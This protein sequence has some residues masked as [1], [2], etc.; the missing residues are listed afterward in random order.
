MLLF[1]L[2]VSLQAQI[3]MVTISSE[4][5]LD[6]VPIPSQVHTDDIDEQTGA[7]VNN[8]VR[9]IGIQKNAIRKAQVK[10]GLVIKFT[11]LNFLL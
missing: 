3:R 1:S 9:Q 4:C 5:A 6:E 11:Y 8:L 7:M 2:H 10:N